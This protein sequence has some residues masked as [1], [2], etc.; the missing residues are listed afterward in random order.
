M[1]SKS[2]AR[3]ALNFVTVWRRFSFLS[4][5]ASLAMR[6]YLVPE[7]KAKR[8]E[9]RTRLIVRLRRGVDGDVHPADRVDLVVFDLGK[10]DLLLH[11][12]AV[13]AAAVEGA[14]G[15]AAE[16]ADARD[17]DVHQA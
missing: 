1:I 17:R 2:A 6:F 12:E 5:T 8:G 15:Y 13:V 10:N 9:E 3:F 4:F 7:G 14:V 11:A 16:V